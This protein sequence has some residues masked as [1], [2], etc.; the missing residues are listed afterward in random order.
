MKIFR[1]VW[2]G[3]KIFRNF[4]GG[5]KIFSIPSAKKIKLHQFHE[6]LNNEMH[7]PIFSRFPEELKEA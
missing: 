3:M 7:F 1:K 5:T 2:G 6:N 4:L